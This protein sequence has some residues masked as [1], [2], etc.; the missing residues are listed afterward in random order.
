MSKG[1]VLITFDDGLVC[2]L[3]AAEYLQDR[4]LKGTFG[5]VTSKIAGVGFLD[6]RHLRKMA[7]Q[8][9]CICNHSHEHLWT[10]QGQPK[11]GMTG[12]TQ[13]R[14]DQDYDTACDILNGYNNFDGDILMLPF[15]SSNIFGP[16]HLKGLTKRYKWIRMTIGCPVP[17]DMGWWALTGGKRL[18][19]Y[20]YDDSVIGI[21]EAA[22]VRRPN[23]VKEWV[24][25][26]VKAEGLCVLVYHSICHVVGETQAVMWDR[27]VSDMDYIGELV[28]QGKLESITPR[29]LLND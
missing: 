6:S 1:Q 3:E 8:G 11:D 26:A 14:I 12:Q 27:F 21:T 13:E 2:H 9:H 16:P 18:Y 4:E 29:E 17:E 15:G 22:D 24:D 7:E 23:G 5:I 25:A 20:K 19:P 28:E 10:G